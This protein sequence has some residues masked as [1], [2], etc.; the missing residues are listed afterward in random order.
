MADSGI[1]WSPGHFYQFL[2]NPK[3]Y[4][5]GYRSTIRLHSRCYVFESIH[6]FIV[7]VQSGLL[8]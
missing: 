2:V 5:G 3:K 4:A 7:F 8:K 6:A 1:V